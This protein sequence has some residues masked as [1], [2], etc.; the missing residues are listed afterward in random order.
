MAKKPFYE[1]RIVTPVGPD[2]DGNI[3]LIELDIK[4]DDDPGIHTISEIKKDR[5]QLP[6]SDKDTPLTTDDVQLKVEPGKDFEVVNRDALAKIYADPDKFKPIDIVERMEKKI[7]RNLCVPSHVHAYSVCVEFFKNYILSQFNASFFKTVYIEGKHLFDDWAK[8]NIN[9]MIKRGKPAIAIIPQ[10]DTDFNRDGIDANN[11]DLTYYARTF[12]YRDTFFKDRERDKY[13]AIAFEQMLMNF[14]VRIKVNTKA[15]QIDIMKYLKM[16]LKVGAT[17][18]KYLDMD[19]HV[20]QEM[21][22]ALAQDVGFDVDLEKKEIKDPFKF[23]VY[24]N[25]KSEV[26]F[27]YKL[28]AINGRNEFFIRAKAMYT[29]I[30][31]PDINIDDGERQGQ[32]SSNY[33]IEF[34]TEIRMPA[35]KVYCYFT[36]KHTNLIEF[37]DNAGNIKSYVANFA[38]VPTLNERGWEQFFTLDYEDKKDKVLEISIS[39]IFDGDPYINKLIKYCKS[40]FISPSVFIDFKIVNNNKIVDIDVNWTDMVINTIKPVDFEYSEIVVYT[41]KAYMNSQLLAMEQD[42]GYRVVYNKD[43]ESENYPIHDNRN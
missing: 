22:L 18:G 34:T 33:F 39:D 8:L 1:Y 15:K 13:I 25:S 4:R 19:I 11:Y 30:A 35:P 17:S 6:R 41:D 5:E 9:D 26:P 36:A 24:L 32:V 2:N 7:Y 21:L 40:K 31:T 43:P 23:L 16:A 27:I 14:Q 38:N 37:T 10:L 20:P 42:S 29:H 28:R 12:N 3:P